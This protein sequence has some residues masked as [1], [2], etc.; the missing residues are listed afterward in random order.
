MVFVVCRAP[1][2]DAPY[3]SGRRSLAAVDAVV[4]PG[5]CL[6]AVNAAPF[7]TG[8]VGA[9]TIALMP[10][11][12]WRRL[13]TALNRNGRY[14]FTTWRW[15]RLLAVLIVLGEFLKTALALAQL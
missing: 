6:W 5:L 13:L 7:Q 15:G 2:P 1:V 14:R 12:T 11:F 9:L 4:W 8:V 3:W 10:F